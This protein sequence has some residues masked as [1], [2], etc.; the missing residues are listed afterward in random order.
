MV[1]IADCPECGKRYKVSHL[2]KI[3]SCK[4]CEV[5]LIPEDEEIDTEFEPAEDERDPEDTRG[6]ALSKE[7]Q[8]EFRKRAREASYKAAKRRN[9]LV[10]IGLFALIFG[11]GGTMFAMTRGRSVEKAAELFREAWNQGSYAAAAQLATK[12]QVPQWV[13]RLENRDRRFEWNGTPPTLGRY[14]F[15]IDGTASETFQ[16]KKPNGKNRGAVLV[17]Y[18]TEDSGFLTVEFRRIQGAWTLA[19]MD[20]TGM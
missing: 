8:R 17:S 10:A 9:I 12:E 6:V 1:H 20:Y 4:A 13:E 15:D 14:L 5:A 18:M 2:D 7:D 16:A 11:G 19:A 3:W